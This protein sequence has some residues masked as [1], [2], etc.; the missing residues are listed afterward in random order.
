MIYFAKI[1]KQKDKKYLVEFPELEGCFTEGD[2]LED[3]LN[4]AQEVLDGWLASLCDHHLNIP[5]PKT[6]KGR[7]FHPI[8]VN[9]NIEFVI[10]LRRLRKKKRLS[11]LQ[12]AKR[13]GIS[14]QAYARLETPFKSNPSLNTIEKISKA[15]D[16]ALSLNWPHSNIIIVFKMPEIFSNVV[17]ELTSGDLVIA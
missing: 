7:N 16:V 2:S 3:A 4:N 1:T 15:F 12:V 8:A 5:E 14:Q 13:L 17:D 10:S 6:R 9:V 11:Q